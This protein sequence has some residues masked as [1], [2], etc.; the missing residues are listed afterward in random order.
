[1]NNLAK[2]ITEAISETVKEMGIDKDIF[3]DKLLK[4]F[5]MYKEYEQVVEDEML[6]KAREIQEESKDY[7]NEEFLEV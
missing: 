1:M 6:E 4:N 5:E 2:D 3:F 7:N